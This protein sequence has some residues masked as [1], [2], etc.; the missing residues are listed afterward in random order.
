MTQINPIS[1]YLFIT[2]TISALF[3]VH[4][5]KNRAVPGAIPF[6]FIA[7]GVLIWTASYAFELMAMD[8]ASKILWANIKYLGR[9]IVPGASLFF[10]LKYAGHK[11]K[12]CKWFSAALLVEP[13]ITTYLVWTNNFHQYVRVGTYLVEKGTITLLSYYLGP[14]TYFN[15]VYSNVLILVSLFVL[16]KVLIYTPGLY[17]GQIMTALIAIFIPWVIGVFDFFS[18]NTLPNLDLIPLS[19]LVSATVLIWG[20]LRF[21][22]L[23]VMP[24][25]Q[26]TIYKN[27]R[28]GIVILDQKDRVIHLNPAAQVLFGEYGEKAIG[29]PI[30]LFLFDWKQWKSGRSTEESFSKEV[31]LQDKDYEISFSPIYDWRQVF[32][33]RLLILEDITKRKLAELTLRESEERYRGVVDFLPDGVAM[34]KDGKIVFANLAYGHLVGAETPGELIGKDILDFVHPEYR[35]DVKKRTDLIYREGKITDGAEEKMLRMDGVSIDVEVTAMPITIHGDVYIQAI[36][37]DVTARK[38]AEAQIRLQIAALEAAANSIM[39]TDREGNILWANPAFTHLTGYQRSEIIGRNPRFL[40]SG[41]HDKLFYTDLWHTVLS[42][43]VW[44]GQITN[45]RKDGTTYI[46]D[47]TITPIRDHHGR[48]LNFV[49]IKYDVTDRIESEEALKASETLYRTTIDA[50]E[51]AIHV[52]D[53]NLRLTLFNKTLRKWSEQFG[54]ETKHILGMNLF[55]AFPF[56]SKDAGEEYR[57]VLNSG[58]TSITNDKYQFGDRTF[59]T[60]TRKSLVDQN[61]DK[62]TSRFVTVVRNITDRVQQERDREA[63]ISVASALRKTLNRSEMLPIIL[64]KALELMDGKASL[65]AMVDAGTNEVV[66]EFAEG[67]WKALQGVR[68]PLEESATG[69]VLKDGA[70]YINNDLVNAPGRI[71]TELVGDLSSIV[72]APLIAAGQQ[73]GVI[74]VARKR[75]WRDEDGSILSAI[76]DMAANAIHRTTLYEQTQ[77]RLEQL[78]ALQAVDQAITSTLDLRLILDVLLEKVTT[79]LHVDAADVLLYDAGTSMLRFAARYGFRS[80]STQ[81]TVL[82]LGEGFAGRVVKEGQIIDVPDISKEIKGLH[83]DPIFQLEGFKAYY[84]VPLKA[85][86]QVQGVLQ[87]YHRSPFLV[88]TDWLDFLQALAGQAAIAIDNAMLFEGMRKANVDLKMAYDATIEG[89]ATALE[90]RDKETVGHSRRVVKLTERL[91]QA[92]GIDGADLVN[93]RRGAILHDIGK[94]GVPDQIL[95]KQGPLTT[96]EIDTM[97]KHPVYAHKMLSAIE[98][99]RPALDIPYSHHEKWN[100]KGYPQGLKGK[101]IPLAARIFAVVDVWDA[102]NSDRSYREAW[103]K[104]SV[105]DYIRSQSGKHFDPDVVKAFLKIVDEPEDSEE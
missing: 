94:M 9:A 79:Q 55:D 77:N 83:P 3:V 95:L 38:R 58:L 13:V 31:Y 82:R 61:G 88:S 23:D 41:V 36:H 104:D 10:A 49:A 20:V 43:N 57:N 25:A 24:I 76:A 21:N 84:G 44:R 72:G 91:A 100:G 65:A 18:H 66:F 47:M 4:A 48:I 59:Y 103:T 87:I 30:D 46:E 90:Y 50:M 73:I 40:N 22:F 75:P 63:I 64:D 80:Q 105:L 98:F 51:D 1:I 17:R 86:G 5:L 37:R 54:Y 81:R 56:L 68:F 34:H 101:N 26:S 28:S 14:W 71:R 78:Q 45:R 97:K 19:F 93:I 27:M 70:L 62:K 52:V 92:M 6:A 42:G 7:I 96:E 60:E 39:I 99:L 85:R 11:I 53:T 8:L 67:G 29:K 69:Q 15:L 89:W 16:L 35:S 2:A 12:Y 32:I 102:L 74:W 33:G